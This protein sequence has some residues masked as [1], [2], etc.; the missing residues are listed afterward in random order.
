M[1]QIRL[2][3]GLLGTPTEQI[4]PGLRSLPLYKQLANLP[5]QPYNTLRS[6]FVNP[7][8]HE[9]LSLL[10]GLL[11]Y[12]PDKRTSCDEALEAF[13][14]FRRRPLPCLPELLPTFPDHRK[15]RERARERE[16]DR[17]RERERESEAKRVNFSKT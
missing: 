8:S 1:T 14:Y 13:G 11:T 4:W 5:V 17:E 15:A 12:D 3:I 9:A 10:H 6:Q 16:R 7:P 2:I